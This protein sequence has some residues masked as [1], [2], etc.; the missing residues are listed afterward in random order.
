METSPALLNGTGRIELVYELKPKIYVSRALPDAGMK[1]LYENFDV[2]VHRGQD[3]PSREELLGE[4]GDVQGA[5]VMLTEKIDREF[6]ENARSLKVVSCFSVGVDH[7][8]LDSCT[9]KGIMVTHTPDVLTDATADL[10]FALILAASRRIAEGDRYMRSKKWKQKWTPNLLL[11]YDLH[12]ATL[13]I[14]GFGRIGQALARRAAGFGMKVVYYDHKD[15]NIEAAR[16]L[17]CSY[18]KLDELLRTSDVVSVHLP[19]T[20]ETRHIF[21]DRAFSLMK[22]SAVFVN[23][24]RGSVVDQKALVD[25]L[26]TNKIFAA[27][28]DV[29]EKEPLDEDDPLLQLENVVFVPHLGS[30]TVQTRSAMAE[31]AARNL[32][33]ALSGRVPKAVANRDVLSK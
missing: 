17:D 30:A 24:S 27:G 18:L 16:T 6:I 23:T 5:L 9:E 25:A 4:T 15:S 31:L 22:K 12:G 1:L 29:F 7:V 26:K 14:V 13:G 21:D 8:D 20:V 19:L 11:G 32:V 33:D 28:L 10:A 2:K 3:P